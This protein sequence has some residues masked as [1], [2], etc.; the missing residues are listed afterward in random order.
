MLSAAQELRRRFD[1]SRIVD[2]TGIQNDLSETFTR[3]I[4][5]GEYADAI[6][7]WTPLYASPG[8]YL[9]PLVWSD[10]SIPANAGYG[11]PAINSLLREAA[12]TTDPAIRDAR[13]QEIQQTLLEGYDLIPL[14]QGQDTIAYWG[15]VSGVLV[16]ANSWLRFDRLAK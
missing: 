11:S 2:I 12:L 14:F 10:S 1:D 7:G 8:G 9:I 6:I 15:D 3:A 4:N 16:E 13:Y 5:R